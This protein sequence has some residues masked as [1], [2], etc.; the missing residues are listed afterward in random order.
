MSHIA[1]LEI[2]AGK[3]DGHDGHIARTVLSHLADVKSGLITQGQAKLK[4]NTFISTYHYATNVPDK[5][6]LMDLVKNI[7]KSDLLSL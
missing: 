7:L 4:I 3:S 6:A 5:K 2:I 1:N